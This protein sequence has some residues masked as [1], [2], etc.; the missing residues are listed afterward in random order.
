[1]CEMPILSGSVG[2]VYIRSTSRTSWSLILLS[3]VHKHIYMHVGHPSWQAN[4]A[5]WGVKSIATLS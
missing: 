5:S 4:P 2:T 3:I 1:M